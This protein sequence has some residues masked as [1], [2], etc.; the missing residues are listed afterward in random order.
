[1]DYEE[2]GMLPKKLSEDIKKVKEDICPKC[3]GSL[4]TGWECNKCG[5]DCRPLI[6]PEAN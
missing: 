1:M 4:D 2:T 5:A 6:V 3:G